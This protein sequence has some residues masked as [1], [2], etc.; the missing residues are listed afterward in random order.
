VYDINIMY[1]LRRRRGKQWLYI[2]TAAI[3][4]LGGYG[5]WALKRPLP[6]LKPT[7]SSVQSQTPTINSK[8][9]WPAAGQ[10]SVGLVGSSI[11]E[12]H[13]AQTPTPTASTAKIITALVVVR[14]KPLA[15]GE[16]GPTIT[17][18]ANDVAIYNAYLV[19]DSSLVKVQAGEQISEYQILQAMLLPSA[20][21]MAD[22]L[23]IWAFGSLKAYSGAANKYL[24]SQGLA[25]TTVG[26]DASGFAPDTIST[27]HD[28][29]RIGEL[30][31]HNPVLAQ[32]V[33]QPSTSGI[34]IVNNIKNVNSL[35]GTNG[36]IGVKTG[37]TDQAG[38][39][40][41]SA[42][43][44]TVNGQ[45]V[46]VVTALA[47]SPSLWQAMHD[48]LPLIQ[49]AQANFSPVTVARAGQVI[50]HYRLPWSGSIAAIASRELTIKAW[51]GSTVTATAN[52][53]AIQATTR[54]GKI[55]CALTISDPSISDKQSVPLKLAA[56]PSQPSLWWRLL[57]PLR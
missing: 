51:N 31:M 41:I 23:A 1:T 47:N 5:Y 13:G 8:L 35:L 49:S 19:H 14:A 27:A 29:V 24:A 57:H 37:N 28:L 43:R 9:A 54:G 50:G 42:S 11:L 40:F 52:F 38:G 56:T 10:S 17:L 6:L 53:P 22:S 7:H 44:T 46:T 45:P 21:N 36:I 26:S 12:T 25:A 16:Q 48:S 3:V 20:N 33:G 39:V 18:G 2:L 34:P 15:L 4:L 30:V 55:V 32:I